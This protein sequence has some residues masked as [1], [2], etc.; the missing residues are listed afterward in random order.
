MTSFTAKATVMLLGLPTLHFNGTEVRIPSQ[1]A[2]AILALLALSNPQ[3]V[4]RD[5][6]CSLLWPDADARRARTALRQSL[7]RLRSILKAVDCDSIEFSRDT[8]RVTGP[9]FV[10]DAD[11]MFAAAK[12]GD[13]KWD[14]GGEDSIAENFLIGIAGLTPPLDAWINVQRRLFS[15]RLT[16]ILQERLSRADVMALST[17][18]I[19][20][21]LTSLDP[22]N[23]SA[24]RNLIRSLALQGQPAAAIRVYDELY[25]LLGEDY[26]IEPSDET[27]ALIAKVKLGEFAED[28][29]VGSA[30]TPSEL[31]AGLPVIALRP[32]ARP[33]G[34]PASPNANSFYRDLVSI[35]VRFR[36]WIVVDQYRGEDDGY[37]TLDGTEE[38]DSEGRGTI[39]V[40]LRNQSNG[41]FLW[42][43]R[44]PISFE[45]WRSSHWKISERFAVSIGVNISLERVSGWS[46]M[47]PRSKS[48]FDQWLYC[49]DLIAKWLPNNAKRVEDT[50]KA[51]VS[52]E[53]SFAPAHADLAALYN[54]HH[55]MCAGA[56]RTEGRAQQAM[57]HAKEA[58][59]LDPLDTR[60]QRTLAWSYLMN[61]QYGLAQT[62]FDQ[63]LDLNS[64]NPYT[65]MSTAQGLAFCGQN[66]RAAELACV[67]KGLQ[68][69][70][71]GF[72]EGYQVGISFLNEDYE[73]A[74]AAADRAADAISNLRGWK[75]SA[76]WELGERSAARA[77][78]DDFVEALGPIWCGA[79]SLGRASAYEWFNNAF[80]I[81]DQKMRGRLN[82]GLRDALEL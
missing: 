15:D 59:E 80:P 79:R 1:K 23:E 82:D 10:S 76:L 49:L 60:A 19:A 78:A 27:V 4:S 34:K 16:A 40:V 56:E 11:D 81:R 7:V 70:L 69:P 54:S 77:A 20:R 63:A 35:M 13:V 21:A 45:N 18:D 51:I 12:Q 41:H 61:G 64:T 28:A 32:F 39:S 72:L 36:E 73:G 47:F 3:Q 66:R 38:F 71:P 22:T 57:A 5:K 14:Y 9:S 58:L 52:S 17:L 50:L 8:V 33:D 24:Q 42:S 25:R 2:A 68:S 6:L 62:H 29:P 26:D 46:H 30:A 74:V 55:L 43:E 53:P 44:V 67:A 75:A 31:R 65:V 48:V 37:Y